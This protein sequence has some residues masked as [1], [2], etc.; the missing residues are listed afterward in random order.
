MKHYYEHVHGIT[1]YSKDYVNF[2]IRISNMCMLYPKLLYVSVSVSD[3]KKHLK[4]IESKMKEDEQFWSI[5]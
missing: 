5:V 2:M 3:M 4:Y 1:K